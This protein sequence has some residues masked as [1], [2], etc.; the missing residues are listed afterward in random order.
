[1]MK[2]FFKKLAFVMALAMVVTLAAPAANTAVAADKKPL[3]I[4]YQDGAKISTLNLKNIG[5]KEDLRFLY[6]P[7]NY[8]ELRT[9]D[10]CS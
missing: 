10:W 1:M 3:A 2:S 7:T 5:D 6:A 8:K 9:P 4:A